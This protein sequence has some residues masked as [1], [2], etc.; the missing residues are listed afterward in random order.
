LDID[1][2]KRQEHQLIQKLPGNSTAMAPMLNYIKR[3]L[4]LIS[5]IIFTPMIHLSWMDQFQ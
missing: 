2:G 3:A 4:N 1:F 5:G